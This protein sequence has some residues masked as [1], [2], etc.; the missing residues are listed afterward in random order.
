MEYLHNILKIVT[1]KLIYW[2]AIS[3]PVYFL[4][5]YLLDLGVKLPSIGYVGCLSVIM[6]AQM[7]FRTN[8]PVINVY[9]EHPEELTDQRGENDDASKPK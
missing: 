6:I 2:I 9:I 8:T 7:I 5:E 4:W 3:V 1:E